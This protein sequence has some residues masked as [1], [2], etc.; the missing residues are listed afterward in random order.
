MC[1][2]LGRDGK[3]AVG[4]A[5]PSCLYELLL[6]VD[7]QKLQIDLRILGEKRLG[8]AGARNISLA[9]RSRSTAS[10][11]TRAFVEVARAWVAERTGMK[12]SERTIY[13]LEDASR[14][15]SADIYLALQQVLPELNDPGYI[16]YS[17]FPR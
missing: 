4:P 13:A 11:A 6:V 16:H 10:A 12:I 5:L 15:P 8:N 1:A 3:R 9:V 7:A 2:P 14:A 17:R